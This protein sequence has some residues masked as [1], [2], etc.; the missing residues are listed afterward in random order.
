MARKSLAEMLLLESFGPSTDVRY[1]SKT[2]L[3]RSGIQFLLFG[4]GLFAAAFG[5]LSVFFD[6]M[7]PALMMAI[8]FPVTIL[9]GMGVLGGLY[10][11]IRG[12]FRSASYDPE[13][14][15]QADWDRWAE[16]EE[17]AGSTD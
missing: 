6:F 1:M 11:C 8:S 16:L 15:R 5:F 17:D 7:P 14:V 12:V 3:F 9:S 4:I 10:L 13:A 2:Q